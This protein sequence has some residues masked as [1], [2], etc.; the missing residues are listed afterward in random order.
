MQFFENMSGDVYGMKTDL[1]NHAVDGVIVIEF[2]NETTQL[3]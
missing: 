2:V 3:Q 1:Y